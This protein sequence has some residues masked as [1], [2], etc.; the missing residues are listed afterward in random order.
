LA[1]DLSTTPAA[2]RR[3]DVPP[4]S[5]GGNSG[6]K[7]A[8]IIVVVI[9]AL[10]FG[11]EVFVPIALSIL[12]SFALA[13]PVRWLRRI[14]VPRI[15][16]VISVVALAFAALAAFSMVV[17]WQVADLAQSL[18]SYQRNIEAKID[19]FRD[20]PP[21]GALFDRATSMIRDLGRKIEEQAEDAEAVEETGAPA[22]APIPVQV[23]EPDLGRWNWCKHHRAAC[24]PARHLS[25]SSSSSSS[26]CCSSGRISAIA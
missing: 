15:L 13:P 11:R 5:G 3:L 16:A 18:P 1:S 26:S 10:Y 23:Q 22:P 9:A 17:A 6:M 14:H 8:A 2:P 12:L 21:G 7:T 4:V 25:A 24:R 20:A 19:S